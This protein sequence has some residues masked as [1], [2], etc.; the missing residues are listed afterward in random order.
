MSKLNDLKKFSDRIHFVRKNLNLTMAEFANK[1]GVSKGSISFWESG[2]TTPPATTLR[3][4]AKLFNL[5][6][7]WLLTGEGEI[8]LETPVTTIE[9]E[10]KG[11]TFSERLDRIKAA[12]EAVM[13]AL[14]KGALSLDMLDAAK[15]QDFAF[16]FNLNAEQLI[17]MIEEGGIPTIYKDHRLTDLIKK[18][19]RIYAYGDRAEKAW[20]RGVIEEAYDKVIERVPSDQEEIKKGHGN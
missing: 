2:K 11:K 20:V 1:I 5:N 15:I 10:L 12:T 14:N 17:K 8:Y 3:L 16:V 19:E 7:E 9:E 13:E 4:I 18:I 6:P